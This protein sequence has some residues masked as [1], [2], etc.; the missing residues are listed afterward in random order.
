[1]KEGNIQVWQFDSLRIGDWIRSSSF[2]DRLLD[3][4]LEL[5]PGFG[6]LAQMVKD[7]RQRYSCG[8]GS[9]DAVPEMGQIYNRQDRKA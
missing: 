4:F 7:G 2:S 8:V 1:M 9:G 6:I 3:L 5:L